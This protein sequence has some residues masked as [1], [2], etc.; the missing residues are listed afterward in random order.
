MKQVI[1]QKYTNAELLE[2]VKKANE[3]AK[4]L[5][6]PLSKRIF[7]EYCRINYGSMLIGIIS[8]QFSIS[9]AQRDGWSAVLKQIGIE[10]PKK[11]S[12]ESIIDHL[13]E[14]YIEKGKQPTE[15]DI[16]KSGMSLST[17]YRYFGKTSNAIKSMY[18]AKGVEQEYNLPSNVAAIRKLDRAGDSLRHL[19]IGLEESPVNEQGVV[20]LFGKIHFAIGFPS[21][22]KVQ[23]DFPDCKAYSIR[24][25]GQRHRAN[26]E[27]KYKSSSYYRSKRSAEQWEDKVNYLVC[28]EHDCKSFNQ[29]IKFVQ[30]IALKDELKKKEVIEVI[31]SHYSGKLQ[32]VEELI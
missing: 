25:R 17:V 10:P 31:K 5:N 27:F 23:Q 26:I 24:V 6:V 3:K 16:A 18:E 9:A 28:W 32:V 19:P 11:F 1:R 21:I 29:K 13:Y 14:L 8:K 22:I 4:A 15:E 7:N 12:A 30:V 20:L 2:I